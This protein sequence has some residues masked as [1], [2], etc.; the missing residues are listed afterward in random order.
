MK[1]KIREALAIHFKRGL[2]EIE[3]KALLIHCT[4]KVGTSAIPSARRLPAGD[5]GGT[6]AGA[7]TGT[8]SRNAGSSNLAGDVPRACD[9]GLARKRAA[10]SVAPLHRCL[11]PRRFTYVRH[12][13][14]PV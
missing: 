2:V 12:M 13:L 5:R 10:P 3:L 6:T 8:G 14:D 11:P 4:S 1:V 9:A 7:S